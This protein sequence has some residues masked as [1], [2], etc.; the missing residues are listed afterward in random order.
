MLSAVESKNQLFS[1]ESV[2]EACLA[3][4]LARQ[5][6]IRIPAKSTLERYD[7]LAPEGEIRDLVSPLL[8]KAGGTDHAGL[9]LD[10]EL[11]V[12]LLLVD[13]LKGKHP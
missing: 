11:G 6:W 1:T 3:R 12:D 5:S 8:R 2:A 10:A 4:I 13:L 9:G 7:K